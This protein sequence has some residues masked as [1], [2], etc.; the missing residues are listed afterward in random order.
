MNV[1]VQGERRAAL[2]IIAEGW[3][4]DRH[5]PAPDAV[6][7]GVIPADAVVLD[8]P[9]EEAFW[10]AI[11]Q[12]RA[13]RGGY[14]SVNGYSGYQ[15]DHF[16]PTRR[17]IADLRP[18]ALTPFRIVADLYVI[19][20]PGTLPEV[21]RWVSEHP[22]AERLHVGPDAEIFRLARMHPEAP[23]RSLPLPLPRPGT[24]PFGS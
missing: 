7:A 23:R 20:R 3:F 10:N 13:V 24:R 5:V 22:G 18:D 12:Y 21:A 2:A 6:T 16:Q 9:I 11:P 19:V 14:R 15:P 8:L 17:A 1:A 4:S